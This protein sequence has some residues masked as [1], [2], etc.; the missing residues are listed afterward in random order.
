MLH[1][2]AHKGP[3][4]VFV[5]PIYYNGEYDDD[6]RDVFGNKLELTV[7]ESAWV[8]DY[9]AS[10][11][12][13]PWPLA[14]GAEAPTMTLEPFVGGR[15]FNDHINI[16]LDSPILGDIEVFGTQRLLAYGESPLEEFPGFCRIACS[17][18]RNGQVVEAVCHLGVL[19]PEGPLSYRESTLVEQTCRF[20]VS[21]VA[22]YV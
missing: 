22:E 14:Q 16:D 5:S 18:G 3:F 8:L 4:G 15:F 19:R 7:K 13:G 17:E 21:L 6:I 11:E 1:A 9:G 10:F 12:F 20:V 2:E